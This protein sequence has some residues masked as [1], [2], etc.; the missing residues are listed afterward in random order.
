MGQLHSEPCWRW[1]SCQRK[2]IRGLLEH[3]GDGSLVFSR[4]PYTQT[5]NLPALSY[6]FNLEEYFDEDEISS[7][8][9]SSMETLLEETRNQL[10]DVLPMFEK[11]IADLVQDADPMHRVFLAIKGNPSPALSRVVS[12]FSFL[13]I[14]S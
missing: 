1:I 5:L 11:N 7:L 9:T 12:P 4:F 8:A 13:K 2:G 10:R 14:R 6:S 3:V